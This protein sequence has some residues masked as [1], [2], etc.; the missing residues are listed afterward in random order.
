MLKHF[1]EIS[2]DREEIC[3]TTYSKVLW[4][5]AH[6]ENQAVWIQPEEAVCS[7]GEVASGREAAWLLGCEV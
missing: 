4:V 3:R 6:V 1:E 2:D 7:V 5:A